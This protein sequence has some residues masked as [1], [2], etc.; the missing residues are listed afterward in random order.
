MGGGR[1]GGKVIFDSCSFDGG[2]GGLGD[3]A[4]IY[5][6]SRDMEET[7]ETCTIQIKNCS[8]LKP[9]NAAIFQVPWKTIDYPM[10]AEICNCYFEDCSIAL[11]GI[12]PIKLFCKGNKNHVDISNESGSLVEVVK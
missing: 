5:V 4:G 11:V 8:F 9:G 6:H 1:I 10:I 7:H 2:E 3:W 12:Q